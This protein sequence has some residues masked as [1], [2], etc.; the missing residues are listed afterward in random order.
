MATH[1]EMGRVNGQV[2]CSCISFNAGPY[3]QPLLRQYVL[4]LMTIWPVF[5]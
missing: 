2:V 1:H 3:I 5:N 4:G